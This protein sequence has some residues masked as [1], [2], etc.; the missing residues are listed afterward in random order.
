MIDLAALLRPD[1]GQTA[2]SLQLVD[3]KGFEDWVKA[4][5][6]RARQAIEA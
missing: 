2:I 1:Q 6:A 4:Q 3:K 5:P